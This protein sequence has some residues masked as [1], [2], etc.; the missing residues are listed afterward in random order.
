MKLKT[1]KKKI[2]NYQKELMLYDKNNSV[3][4]KKISGLLN[5][6]NSIL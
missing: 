1:W 3:L 4:K 5:K 2:N 6:S